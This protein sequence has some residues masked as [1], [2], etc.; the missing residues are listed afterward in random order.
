[1]AITIDMGGMVV[2]DMGAS[3]RFSRL[4]GLPIPEGNHVDLFA[5]L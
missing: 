3:L 1:M 2:K 4:L 5:S